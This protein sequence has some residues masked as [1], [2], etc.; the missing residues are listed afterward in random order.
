MKRIVSIAIAVCFSLSAIAQHS[1]SIDLG[2]SVFTGR[3]FYD[4]K[5]YDQP[6]LAP[7]WETNYKT[8]YLWSAGLWM[9]KHI[10]PHLAALTEVRYVTEDV[11]ENMLCQCSTVLEVLQTDE[12]HYWGMFGAGVR[13]YINPTSKVA[14][15]TDAGGELDWLIAAREKRYFMGE[16]LTKKFL[17]WNALGY[18]RFMP[19]AS[20]SLGVKWKRLTLSVGGMTNL[21]RA[22]IRNPG[23]YDQVVY[24]IKTGFLGKGLFVKTTFTLIK[25]R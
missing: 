24:P 17:D 21:Y 6:G 1:E 18:K 25:L 22:M 23:T 15:F 5:Y 8:N 7:G 10:N 9:E 2:I 12:K 16:H 20:L 13:Y 14:L 4:K 19:S 11:P 3:S